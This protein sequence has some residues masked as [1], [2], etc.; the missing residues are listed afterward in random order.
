[1]VFMLRAVRAGLICVFALAAATAPASAQDA[2]PLPGS[3]IIVHAETALQN[4]SDGLWKFAIWAETPQG[5]GFWQVQVDRLDA[6]KPLADDARA[7]L[8]NWTAQARA[9]EQSA[10]PPSF[11]LDAA[12]R[13]LEGDVEALRVFADYAD[14]PQGAAYWRA[15]LRYAAEGQP[16][17]PLAYR[18]LSNWV[19]KAEAR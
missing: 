2:G 5:V 3:F 4:D 7:A 14:T 15:Q 6:G 13:A 1:M 10:P 18:T 11:Q 17:S 8:E 9:G 19:A 12:R 16:M